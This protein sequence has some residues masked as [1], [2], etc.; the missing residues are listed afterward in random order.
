MN[1]ISHCEYSTHIFVVFTRMHECVLCEYM[2]AGLYMCAYLWSK[3]N[4]L[5]L[6]H[7]FVI[8]AKELLEVEIV[9]LF[10]LH[11]MREIYIVYPESLK[12]LL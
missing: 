5:R 9:I 7:P 11:I 10:N 6:L 1:I 8:Y 2:H 3:C 12:Y 4:I